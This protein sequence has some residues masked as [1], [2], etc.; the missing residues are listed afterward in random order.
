MFEIAYNYILMFETTW[1]NEDGDS[2]IVASGCSTEMNADTYEKYRPFIR[3]M[4]QNI[5]ELSNSIEQVGFNFTDENLAVGMFQKIIEENP[6]MSQ[7]EKEDIEN[8][9]HD[10]CKMFPLPYQK[11]KSIN[12][13]V[14]RIPVQPEIVAN[15]TINNNKHANTETTLA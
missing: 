11:F 4:E 12:V 14:G 8:N 9:L 2:K 13:K 7:T 6:E 15:I 10:F 3:V 5:E 1:L